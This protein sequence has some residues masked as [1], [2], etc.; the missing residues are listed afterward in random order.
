VG[1]S[2]AGRMIVRVVARIAMTVHCST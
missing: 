2:M 1:V